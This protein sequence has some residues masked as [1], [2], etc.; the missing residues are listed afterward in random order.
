MTDH[1]TLV[2]EA[3][4]KVIR[5]QL[6]NHAAYFPKPLKQVVA[7][8]DTVLSSGFDYFVITFPS[9]FPVVP[10]GVG[11]IEVAWMLS[12]EFFVRFTTHPETWRRF[13]AVRSDLFSLFNVDHIGRTLNRTAGVRDV[14]LTSAGAPV[15]YGEEA[16]PNDPVFFSQKLE[17]SIFYKINRT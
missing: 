8:D 1:Y 15:F 9:T 14:L 16:T 17:L 13:K 11:V 12:L 7:S 4:L 3:V 2:E 5:E 10:Q 6:N